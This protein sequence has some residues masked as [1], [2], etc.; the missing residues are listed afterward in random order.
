MAVPFSV[1][2]PGKPETLLPWLRL[3]QISE[4]AYIDGRCAAAMMRRL[5]GSPSGGTGRRA[6]L[7]IW[8]S[9]GSGGSSPSWGTKRRF[10]ASSFCRRIAK[11]IIRKQCRFNAQWACATRHAV[12][13]TPP[14]HLGR[15]PVRR[16]ARR[17]ISFCVALRIGSSPTPPS[18]CDMSAT[19][20]SV[21]EQSSSARDVA[22]IGEVQSGAAFVCPQLAGRVVQYDQGRLDF[23]VPPRMRLG[24]GDMPASL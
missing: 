15:A 1:H 24:E 10:S 21:N 19:C 9:R 22:V 20:R 18:P 11:L 4:R 17:T 13:R 14:E 7:K 3:W 8:F 6:R 16:S 23:L 2:G 5:L 12:H